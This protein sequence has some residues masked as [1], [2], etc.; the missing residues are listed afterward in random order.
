MKTAVDSQ[1]AWPAQPLAP[2][3]LPT[4]IAATVLAVGM[5][6]ARPYLVG[7]FFDDGVYVIL[8]KALAT[9]QGY[10]YLHLPGHPV[11]THYPPGYPVLL[12]ALWRI[13][14]E[15]PANVVVF[16]F[17]NALLLAAAA[18]GSYFFAR[19]RLEFSPAWSAAVAIGGSVAIPVLAQTTMVISE[20]LFV[21]LLMPTLLLAERAMGLARDEVRTAPDSLTGQRMA[22][23]AGV[24]CGALALVRSIGAVAI[25]AAVAVGIARRR[26]RAA[27]CVGLSSL[28]LLVP[29][30]LWLRAHGADLAPELRGAYGPYG[31]WV[32]DAIR[33]HGL[34]FA[35]GTANMNVIGL[36]R[37]PLVQM[38][39]AW[40]AWAKAVALA[41]SGLLLVVGFRR[42]I[43]AAPVTAAFYCLYMTEVVLWPFPPYR[44]FWTLWP[45]TVMMCALAIR[46]IWSWRP[47]GPVRHVAR[48]AALVVVAVPTFAFAGY[49]VA[50]YRGHWWSVMQ[51]N[52]SP[53]I[54]HVVASVARHAAPGGPVVS[55]EAPAVYLY[56]GREG[57]PAQ[58]FVADEFVYH[59]DTVRDRADLD[60]VLRR[61]PAR[62][63]VA[64]S[65]EL[66]VAAQRLSTQNPP[67][68]TTLDP[69]AP[70]TGVATFTRVA[71]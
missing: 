8:A 44:F 65:P 14:P 15:F 67:V 47:V 59:R 20:P 71:P 48:A 27:A 17:A 29:W 43:A 12:A 61:F 7:S 13:A 33:Q 53:R 22:L 31:A 68:L 5:L 52:R 66:V 57:L 46:A 24:M 49:N 55:E 35:V 23:V 2:F 54:A 50:G 62:L 10:R 11:A 34:S 6:A 1:R 56:A 30:N 19:K 36:L 51:D 70:A 16:Q 28:A 39:P 9:G 37:I 69:L 32:L 40:P 21:A 3:A 25:P 26:Y 45:V 63:V 4:A 58:T 42:L 64:S 41:G 38:T 18:A 60:A